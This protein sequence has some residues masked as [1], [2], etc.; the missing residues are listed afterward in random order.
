MLSCLEY[1]L[2]ECKLEK[3]ERMNLDKLKGLPEVSKNDVISGI[4]AFYHSISGCVLDSD[5]WQE[6]QALETILHCHSYK[7]SI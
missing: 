1:K 5:P 7:R 3:F 6:S 2:E 4:I